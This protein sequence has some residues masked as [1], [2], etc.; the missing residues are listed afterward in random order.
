MLPR[1]KTIIFFHS[2]AQGPAARDRNG[3]KRQLQ[4]PCWLI[5]GVLQ[6]SVKMKSCH[7]GSLA[8]FVTTHKNCETHR[9]THK[10]DEARVS[11]CILGRKTFDKI[12]NALS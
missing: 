11:I 1:Q 3:G 12:E 4:G 7:L 2:T 9:G 6:Q 10:N 5:D 8:P